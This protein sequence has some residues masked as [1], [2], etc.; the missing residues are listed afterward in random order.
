MIWAHALGTFIHHS[1]YKTLTSAYAAV[2][3][4]IEAND[5]QIVDSNRESYIES[6]QE[7]DH[8]L[9]VTKLQFSVTK[10]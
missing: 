10:L 3:Q 5:Y 2:L 4:W 9:Y 1:H 6:G 7:Q 8:E